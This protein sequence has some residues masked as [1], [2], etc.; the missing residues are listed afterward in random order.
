METKF[1]ELKDVTIDARSIVAYGKV[2][3][4]QTM[5]TPEMYALTIWLADV[6]EPITATYDVVKEREEQFQLIKTT[7][8]TLVGI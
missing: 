5:Q 7:I 4:P 2:T 3:I 8:N 6:R 1:V